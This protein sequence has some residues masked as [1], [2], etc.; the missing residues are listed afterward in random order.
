MPNENELK[1]TQ[2]GEHLVKT[3]TKQ[4]GKLR[5]FFGKVLEGVIKVA[6]HV[7]SVKS[8]I[9]KL[10]EKTKDDNLIMEA[11][12]IIPVEENNDSLANT[13]QEN[14]QIQTQ[15]NSDTSVLESQN[16]VEPAQ[17]K[18]QSEPIKTIFPRTIFSHKK[19]ETP[20]QNEDDTI[21]PIELNIPVQKEENSMEQLETA[22]PQ[23][24]ITASQEESKKSDTELLEES[25]KKYG[26][27]IPYDTY[28]IYYYSFDE[29]E[30]FEKNQNGELLD[31]KSFSNI[32]KT[33]AET[34]KRITQAE[35]D[36]RQAQI[37][38]INQEIENRKENIKN[39]KNDIAHYQSEIRR[40]RD[41]NT[42]LN[43]ENQ[44]GTDK[45]KN[46]TKDSEKANA[47]IQEMDDI[48]DPMELI[49]K[50]LEKE[51][52]EEAKKKVEK[53]A[54]KSNKNKIKKKVEEILK[55]EEERIEKQSMNQNSSKT[56]DFIEKNES[57]PIQEEIIPQETS[58][59]D[60]LTNF[61]NEKT[62]KPVSNWKNNYINNTTDS[63]AEA[64]KEIN[65][66]EMTKEEKEEE[67]QKLY[68]Q[69]DNFVEANY[70]SETKH[71]TR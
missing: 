59:A 9:S 71:R 33:Q 16:E 63:F 31:E 23:E 61:D 10:S 65:N 13:N 41:E 11:E 22:K 67:R 40:L 48:I 45:V 43:K 68:D 21:T 62:E 70:P 25:R 36:E 32:R 46:L 58:L 50:H 42:G 69:F 5:N 26:D 17:V 35:E 18:E 66:S 24:E 60:E 29:Q 39:N 19:E 55:E 8:F 53:K 56:N 34:I 30:R 7:P 44:E 28:K 64:E 57:T 3:S 38:K 2:Y 54:K 4:S 20:A 6:S 51:N 37:T 12:N 27:L 49:A 52:Q 1:F 47:K 15:L 14:D